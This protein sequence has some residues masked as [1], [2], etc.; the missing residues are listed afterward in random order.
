MDMPVSRKVVQLGAQMDASA[1]HAQL[2]CPV[3]KP[4]FLY[5]DIMTSRRDIK[6]GR[7][8]PDECAVDLDVG[9]GGSGLDDERSLSRILPQGALGSN[10]KL[11]HIQPRI[12]VHVGS[13]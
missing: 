12:A 4:H 11:C 1:G 8:V 5:S 9:T 2:L 7:R 3:S 6:S 10:P 13:C